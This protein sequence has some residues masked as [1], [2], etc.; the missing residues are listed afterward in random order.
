MLFS[1]NEP[2]PAPEPEPTKS[3]QLTNS[4]NDSDKEE[5][6]LDEQSLI[7]IK[8]DGVNRGLVGEIIRRFENKGLSKDKWARNSLDFVQSRISNHGLENQEGL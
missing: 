6:N 3:D 5:Q 4:D 8:P 7:M 2:E 1:G